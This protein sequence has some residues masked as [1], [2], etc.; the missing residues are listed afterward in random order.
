M[1]LTLTI[2]PK[3]L[4]RQA[5]AALN[6]KAYKIFLANNTTSLTADSTA[7]LW[8]AAEVPTANGYA[9]V[10]GTT[11]TGT[12]VSGNGR[13]ELP[14]LVAAFNATGA[15]FTYNTV[16]LHFTGATYLHSIAVE[17]PAITL[18]AGSSKSYTISLIQDD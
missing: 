4:E 15:G 7:A 1:A 11:G 10:T 16:C 3:E 2:A 5:A 6:G 12:Y 9:A 8:A 14:D 17:A 13:V 18:S